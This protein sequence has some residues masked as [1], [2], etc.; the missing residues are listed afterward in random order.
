MVKW[1]IVKSGWGFHKELSTAPPARAGEIRARGCQFIMRLTAVKLDPL[2]A[3]ATLVQ[4]Q[5]FKGTE[6]TSRH[7]LPLFLNPQGCVVTSEDAGTCAAGW[8]ARR[9]S[10]GACSHHGRAGLARCALQL[11]GAPA[12]MATRVSGAAPATKQPFSGTCP[13]CCFQMLRIHTG[14]SMTC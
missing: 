2:M 4:Q 9:T 6:I 1:L 10:T 5:V 7:S 14:T 8:E 3:S 11:V 12:C 13:P